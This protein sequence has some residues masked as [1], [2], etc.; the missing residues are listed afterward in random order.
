V[1]TV[2]PESVSKLHTAIPGC[3]LLFFVQS[4][5]LNEIV[6]LLRAGAIGVIVRDSTV[7]DLARAIIAAGRGEIVLPQE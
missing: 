3:E 5:N 1:P 7:G 6:G 2:Q 4:Y